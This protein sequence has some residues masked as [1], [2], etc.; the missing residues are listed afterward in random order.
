MKPRAAILISGS[1]T[2]MT[3]LAEAVAA[4]ELNAEITFVGSDKENAAGLEK[5]E[6]LGLRT[7]VFSYK[8]GKSKAEDAI[9]ASLTESGSEWVILAGYMRILSADFVKK[10]R[11]RIVNIHPSL[12]PAFPGAHAIDDAWNSGVKVTG[13][14]IHLVDELVDHGRILAQRAVEITD[15]DTLETLEAKIHRTEHQLYKSAL[16]KLFQ[17]YSAEANDRVSSQRTS[18]GDGLTEER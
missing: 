18:G 3:A 15:E 2:N 4:G 6:K 12:L 14:T 17:V 16:K 5:A 11:E 9:T 7:E 1:G 13:V 10:Y 8:N